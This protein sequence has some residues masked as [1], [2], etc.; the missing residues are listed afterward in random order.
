MT[1]LVELY[2]FVEQG[3]TPRILTLTNADRE[4]TY[5]GETYVPATLSRTRGQAKN[6]LSKAN[7]EVKFD[8]LNADARRW[9]ASY[10][11]AIVVLTIFERDE[12]GD[13]S[14]V[15]KGRLAS[16]KPTASEISLI[17]ESVFTSLRRPGVRARYQRTCRH[18]LYGRGCFLN[19]AAF[20]VNGAPTAVNG[21]VVTVPEAASY[22]DGW[23]TTGMI[24]AANG[25]LRFVTNHSGSQLTLM[26]PFLYLAKAVAEDGYGLSYGMHYGGVSVIM[27][28]GCDR[29]RGTCN[30]KFNNLGNYGGFDWIPL[31]NPFDGSSIL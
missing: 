22:P 20:A 19:K 1:A 26:Q 16:V 18:S 7:L 12:A 30:T 8:L 25:E 3:A 9:M 2:R 11:E 10:L 31:R 5:N 15:W 14:I 24:E 21:L 13:T 17:F 27:Y 23:F 4:I 6:E 29:R 28:P